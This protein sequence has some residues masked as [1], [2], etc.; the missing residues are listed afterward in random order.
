MAT[1]E[2]E[3]GIKICTDICNQVKRIM[4][5]MAVQECSHELQAVASLFALPAIGLGDPL[6]SEWMTL[7]EFRTRLLLNSGPVIAP[8]GLFSMVKDTPK[9]K[10]TDSGLPTGSNW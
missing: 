3:L 2:L 8:C 5:A 9:K 6:P 10:K 4:S 1:T 7:Q